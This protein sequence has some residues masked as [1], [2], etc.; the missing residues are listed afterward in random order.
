[1]K[2]SSITLSPAR[3]HLIGASVAA[4]LIGAS[5]YA[6]YSSWESHQ[7]GI[8]TS[9]HDLTQVAEQLSMTQRERGRLVDQIAQLESVVNTI[10]QNAQPSSI[11]E[12]AAQVVALTEQYELQLDRF[13]PASAQLVDQVQVLPIQLRVIAPYGSVTSWL[14]EI[15]ASM[16]DIHVVAVS[17]ISQE[18]DIVSTDIRFNWYIPTDDT[19]GQK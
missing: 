19:P 14:D 13:E 1:M 8:E 16:P 10:N 12:L 2:A 3:I 5:A 15:H 7:L 6:V 4:V 11:N 9:K 17:L 18:A